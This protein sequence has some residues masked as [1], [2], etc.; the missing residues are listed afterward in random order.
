[1]TAGIWVVET[2]CGEP[3]TV[4]VTTPTGGITAAPSAAT[5]NIL[6]KKTDRCQRGGSSAFIVKAQ[7]VRH[8]RFL[9]TCTYWY[10]LADYQSSCAKDVCQCVC[11]ASVV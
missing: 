1:M 7:H 3:T 5:T 11:E 8:V 10:V 4:G 6:D 2:S 9:C